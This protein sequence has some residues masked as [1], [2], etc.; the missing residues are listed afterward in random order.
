MKPRPYTPLHFE[1]KGNHLDDKGNALPYTRTTQRAKYSA[2]YA[3]YQGWK[4]YVRMCFEEYTGIAC[5]PYQM[6]EV[7]V[8]A[9][10]HTRIYFAN[11]KHADPDNVQKGI[12]DAIFK[13]DKYVA[14]TYDFDYDKK[15]PRVICDLIF[16]QNFGIDLKILHKEYLT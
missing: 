14:G 12:E 1:I 9:Y 13:N 8:K 10:L 7:P 15:N 5:N 11:K 16:V 3:R 6:L 4:D 2:K